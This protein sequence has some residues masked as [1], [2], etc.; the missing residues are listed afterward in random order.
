MKKRVLSAIKIM[1]DFSLLIVAVIVL[2]S[3]KALASPQE[4]DLMYATVFLSNKQGGSIMPPINWT[5]I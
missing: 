3:I 2:D 4:D 5:T 1:S